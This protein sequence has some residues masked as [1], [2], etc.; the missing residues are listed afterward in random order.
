[1]AA[2]M[3]LLWIVLPRAVVT[4]SIYSVPF[5]PRKEVA[6]VAAERGYELDSLGTL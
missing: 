5:S 6:R 2:R 3:S 1:M 4:P